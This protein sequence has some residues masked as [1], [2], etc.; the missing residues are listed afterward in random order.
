MTIRLP[1]SLLLAILFGLSWALGAA[2]CA[3]TTMA[4]PGYAL[5]PPS[6]GHL[7]SNQ[8]ARLSASLPVGAGP[9]TG[10]SSFIKAVDGRDVSTLDSLFDLL[11][12]CHVVQTASS[13]LMSNGNVTMTGQIGSR[14]FAFPMKAAFEYAVVL[15]LIEGMGGGGRVS[16]YGVE[17]DATGKQ[18]A[19]FQAMPPVAAA[20]L[21]LGW[22]G[23]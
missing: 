18:T 1:R 15:E 7:P 10:A 13:L 19:T 16:V 9:G 4:S 21:C 14:A 12:G 22:K 8:V 20:Q 17:K 3:G 5:Y 6:R 2:G 11:P 23:P